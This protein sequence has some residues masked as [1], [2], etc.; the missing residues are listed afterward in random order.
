M[1]EPINR[2]FG[3]LVGVRSQLDELRKRSRVALVSPDAAALRAIGRNV[4]DPARR[5]EAARAGRAQAAAAVEQIAE[6]WAG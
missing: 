2:G 3:P 1:N 5:A 6:V 4:L